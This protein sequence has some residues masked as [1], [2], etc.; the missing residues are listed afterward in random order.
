MQGSGFMKTEGWMANLSIDLVAQNSL[1][2]EIDGFLGGEEGLQKNE[3]CG[4]GVI[5]VLCL[6][7]VYF[8]LSKNFRKSFEV[9]SV[10]AYSGDKGRVAPF[11]P[12]NLEGIA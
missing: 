2:L 7:T 10:H 12:S 6:S 3:C 11:T 1:M 4:C 5:S 9:C 8:E